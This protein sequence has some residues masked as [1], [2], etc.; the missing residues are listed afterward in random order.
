MTTTAVETLKSALDQANLNKL[1]TALQQVQ[2]GTV[3]TPVVHDTGTIT[4]SATV[5]LPSAALLV[6][7][8]RVATSGTA[9][10]VG[11]YLVGDA[12]ATPSK[13]AGGASLGAG[14]ASISANGLTV[15]FPNT[16]TRVT[17]QYLPRPTTALTSAFNRS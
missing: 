14:V 2:L 8:A 15:T 6:Q 4:A 13:P 1:A 9:T 11:S 16:I 10:S 12:S 5:T 17:I 7:A 3:M